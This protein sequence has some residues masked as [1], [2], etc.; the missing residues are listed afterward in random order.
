MGDVKADFNTSDVYRA[1]Y[2]ISQAV[3]ELCDLEVAKLSSALPAATRQL[4]RRRST[5]S[6]GR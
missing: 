4:T 2:L 5:C 6:I 3:N 1:S